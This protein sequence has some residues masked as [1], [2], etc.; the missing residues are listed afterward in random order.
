MACC[1]LLPLCFPFPFCLQAAAAQRPPACCAPCLLATLRACPQHTN[2][3]HNFQNKHTTSKTQNYN[4]RYPAHYT[5]ATTA[6]FFTRS[7]LLCIRTLEGR[8]KS[9]FDAEWKGW[10]LTAGFFVNAWLLG[11]LLSVC[12]CCVLC[13]CGRIAHDALS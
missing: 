2:S 13:V 3:K 12:V 7:I 4:A 9:I 10:V 11:A 1:P 5:I 8:D 6:Y